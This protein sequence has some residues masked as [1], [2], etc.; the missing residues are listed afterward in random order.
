[1]QRNSGSHVKTSILQRSHHLKRFKIEITKRTG[2]QE[3]LFRH[4]GTGLLVVVLVQ[5]IRGIQ[6]RIIRAA[7]R[8]RRL[9]VLVI[10]RH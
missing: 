10:R 7:G 8:R 4:T 1:M 6:G 9:R 5:N 3:V 2:R